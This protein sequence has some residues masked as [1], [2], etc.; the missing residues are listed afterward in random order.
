MP[1]IESEVDTTLS[2]AGKRRPDNDREINCAT[3]SRRFE[4]TKLKPV[5]CSRQGLRAVKA[6]QIAP[7]TT[8]TSLN[9]FYAV[10]HLLAAYH[11]KSNKHRGDVFVIFPPH[12][13]LGC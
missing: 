7:E 9:K 13:M 12:G 6:T 5:K 2:V 1:V 11:S 3:R 4:T 8:A 10:W